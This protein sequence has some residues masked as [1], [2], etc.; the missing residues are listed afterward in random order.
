[1]NQTPRRK[2][3]ELLVILA[4]IL[5]TIIVAIVAF[6]QSEKRNEISELVGNRGFNFVRWELNTLSKKGY[7]A[8][9]SGHAYLS[10]PDQNRLVLDYVEEMGVI[11]QMDRELDAVYATADDPESAGAELQT[12]LR[13]RRVAISAVQLYAEGVLEDQT[14]AMLEN[15]RFDILGVTFPPVQMHLTPLPSMMIVSP[16]DDIRQAYAFPLKHG[17]P[18]PE[19]ETLEV[20]V[21]EDED[22]SALVVPIGGLGVFPA[23][24]VETSNMV[25]LTDVFAH[26]WSHHWLS[27][28]PLGVSYLRTPQTRTM[29]E[30]AANILGEEIGLMTLE[31]FY[32]EFVPEPAPEA[33]EETAEP[34]VSPT[35]EPAR[36]DFREEMRVT[37][38]EVDRLLEAGQIDAAEAYMEAR[39]LI[40]VEN[41][42]NI[43]KLNQAYFAFYGAYADQGG[44]SGADPV[45]PT[46]VE[47]REE[48]VDL[49]D[50]MRKMGWLWSF[51]ELEKLAE[52]NN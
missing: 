20:Q 34:E 31:T 35:D 15:Q 21:F 7:A 33:Q 41:G 19:K 2:R 22:L 28:R 46:V 23:M 47:V 4:S 9:V 27:L 51:E 48:S 52:E 39:R 49:R 17:L 37:R 10:P 18:T 5:A 25:F 11:R 32:P 6:V 1:M 24:I 43:R 50:F 29:N 13:E 42:Y 40:F 8:I 26:E 16:R 30:T 44:A 45:G 14:S 36:F 38:V 12:E 3:I